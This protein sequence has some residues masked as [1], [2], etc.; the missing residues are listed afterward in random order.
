MNRLI[1][2]AQAQNRCAFIIHPTLSVIKCRML[3]FEYILTCASSS[4]QTFP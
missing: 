1:T 2:M 3:Y 4:I